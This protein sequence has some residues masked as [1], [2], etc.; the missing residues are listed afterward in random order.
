MYPAE[1]ET[2]NTSESNI[3]ASYLDLLLSI[4]KDRQL[5]T[6]FYDKHDGFK[7]H[8]TNFPFLSGKIP[9]LPAYCVFNLTAQ[10]ICKTLLLLQMF[11]SEGDAT[12]K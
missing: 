12:F 9:S 2:K 6:S 3:S 11:Y 10:T 4:G 5:H 1:F 8:I 7:S